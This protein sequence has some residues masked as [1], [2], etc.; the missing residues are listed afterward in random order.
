MSDIV[1]SGKE[2]AVRVRQL[3]SSGL[4]LG[5]HLARDLT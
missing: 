4:I 2:R 3:T 5:I 1:H